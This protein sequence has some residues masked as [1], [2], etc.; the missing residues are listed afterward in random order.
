MN[1]LVAQQVALDNALVAPDNRAMIGK[2]NMRINPTKTQKEA[3]YQVVLDTL[4]LSPCYKAF[5]VTTDVPE[6]YMHQFG[7]QSLRSKTPHLT[8][9]SLTK[10]ELYGKTVPDAMMS[11][12][13]METTTYKTYLAFATRKAIHKKAIK[14]TKATTTIMKES[15][16]TADDNIISEDPDVTLE[17]AKS[18]SKTEAKEQE[19]TRLVHETHELSKKK[20][21]DKYQKLKGVQVMSIEERLAADTKKAIKASKLATRPQQTTGSSEGGNDS[22]SKKSDEEEVPWIYSDDDKEDDNDDD[23][24]IDIEETDDEEDKHDNDE[25]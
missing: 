14:R 7:L 9:S 8:S 16:L 12:E 1:P 22:D 5:L 4:K 3:T 24:S 13:I 20:P 21:L 25:T 11:K 18:M 23:Q 17:L 15:S 2:C 19:A 10:K 6:I